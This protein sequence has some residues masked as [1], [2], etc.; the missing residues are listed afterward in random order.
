M[1]RVFEDIARREKVK[2]ITIHDSSELRLFT[3]GSI[4]DE[5]LVVRSTVLL[6][7]LAGEFRSPF[8]DLGYR[9]SPIPNLSH[10][11]RFSAEDDE[12]IQKAT[13]LLLAYTIAEFL[14]N[15][16]LGRF[17]SFSMCLPIIRFIES[18]DP[19][20]KF[21]EVFRELHEGGENGNK[22]YRDLLEML[23]RW[24]RWSDIP[25]YEGVGAFRKM[26]KSLER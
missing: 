13:T 23:V 1:M 5:P 10:P 26:V 19:S 6:T 16:H 25:G 17:M 9:L 24:T 4:R 21:Y 20:M 2:T 11:S 18:K 14:T 3:T 22:E 12:A 7:L 15:K 8:Y